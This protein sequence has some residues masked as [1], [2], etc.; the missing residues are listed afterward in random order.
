MCNAPD[1]SRTLFTSLV[2]WLVVAVVMD[3]LSR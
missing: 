3:Y 1:V 2:V